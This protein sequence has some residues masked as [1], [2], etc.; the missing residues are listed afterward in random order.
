MDPHRLA[1][2]RSLAYHRAIAA[3]V[4]RDAAVLEAA[5]RR[6]E[7]WL[8][9]S[10]SRYH[11]RRWRDIL[12]GDPSAVAAFLGSRGELADELRQSSPFAGVL[13]PGERWEIWRATRDALAG[14]P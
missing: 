3:R 13:S 14:T 11:A 5:R 12:A 10:V 8:A 6:V 4:L 1:E 2:E 9:E 7:G